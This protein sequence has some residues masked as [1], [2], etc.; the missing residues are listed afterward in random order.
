MKEGKK[1]ADSF[2]SNVLRNFRTKAQ[3]EFHEVL[4]YIHH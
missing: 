1:V 4:T 3:L 2:Q